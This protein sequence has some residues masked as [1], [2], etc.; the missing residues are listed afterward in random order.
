MSEGD[1]Y[2]DDEPIEDLRAAWRHGE[3]G[4]TTG[5]RE[6]N[7]RERIIVDR[8]VERLDAAEP[9]DTRVIDT[10]GWFASPG[11]AARDVRTIGGTTTTETETDESLAH[12]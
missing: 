7:R 8:A 2:E 4:R 11:A 3:P 1:F 10:V 12:V 5:P 6:L 9:E